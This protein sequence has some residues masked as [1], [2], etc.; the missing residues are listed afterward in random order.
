MI[1]GGIKVQIW[2]FDLGRR[3]KSKVG[4]GKEG[5]FPGWGIK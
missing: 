3:V 5:V 1:E 4:A 2:V